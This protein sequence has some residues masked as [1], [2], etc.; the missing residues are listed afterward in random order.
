VAGRRNGDPRIGLMIT[1]FQAYLASVPTE[2][3]PGE[4]GPLTLAEVDQAFEFMGRLAAEM[5]AERDGP[6]P[7]NA[8]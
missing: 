8:P 5:K 6:N 7:S 3:Q 1:G 2:R 4:H